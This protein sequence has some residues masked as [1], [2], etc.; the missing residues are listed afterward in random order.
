MALPSGRNGS[1]A[2]LAPQIGGAVAGI[3][4][5]QTSSAHTPSSPPSSPPP[6]F[7]RGA[8]RPTIR[9]FA[10]IMASQN[11]VEILDRPPDRSWFEKYDVIIFVGNLDPFAPARV[12]VAHP[13]AAR[14]CLGAYVRLLQ[15]FFSTPN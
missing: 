1:A 7:L 3:G 10:F 14:G 4:A 11:T 2:K 12:L 8:S 6:L 5:A 15:H 13:S 9:K